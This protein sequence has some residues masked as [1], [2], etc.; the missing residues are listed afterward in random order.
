MQNTLTSKNQACIL[1]LQTACE[2]WKELAKVFV[3][4]QMADKGLTVATSSTVEIWDS[5]AGVSH[6]YLLLDTRI[7]IQA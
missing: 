1:S 3:S 4:T 2:E 5:Q 7:F 6:V